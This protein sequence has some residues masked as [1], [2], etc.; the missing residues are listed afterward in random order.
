MIAGGQ[1]DGQG[2]L[3][4]TWP[5]CQMMSTAA[6]VPTLMIGSQFLGCGIVGGLLRDFHRSARSSAS[7][8]RDWCALLHG[9]DRLCGVRRASRAVKFDA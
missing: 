2:H 3:V 9:N 1:T 4:P 5:L 7:C 8:H 6:N